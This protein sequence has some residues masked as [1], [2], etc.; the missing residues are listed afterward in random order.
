[1]IDPTKCPV[2]QWLSV[3]DHLEFVY[4]MTSRY[5]YA[6][7][8]RDEVVSQVI[9]RMLHRSETYEGSAER[10]GAWAH[11]VIR[12]TSLNFLNRDFTRT[13]A[14][15]W[16]DREEQCDAPSVEREIENEELTEFI[17]QELIPSLPYRE[18]QSLALM[19]E[20][21][22]MLTEDLEARGI[23][24]NTAHGSLRRVRAKVIELLSHQEH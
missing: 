12:T 14:A 13:K 20:K 16:Q 21:G 15:R 1:M 5:I 9:E 10:V 17:E 6:Q 11:S 4:A 24:R 8:D 3:R 18:A 2:R 7:Q 19:W 22:R 23:N